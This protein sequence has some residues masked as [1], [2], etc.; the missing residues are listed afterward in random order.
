MSLPSLSQLYRFSLCGKNT[1]FGDFTVF[2]VSTSTSA[3]SLQGPK[4]TCPALLIGRYSSF[5]SAIAL[6]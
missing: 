6:E 4:F 3:S 2:K 5:V 1:S